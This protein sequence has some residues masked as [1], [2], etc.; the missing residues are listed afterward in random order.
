MVTSKVAPCN[1]GCDVSCSSSVK[2]FGLLFDRSAALVFSFASTTASFVFKD[3]SGL[4]FRF[5]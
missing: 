5:F 4:R 2:M 1:P 3:L